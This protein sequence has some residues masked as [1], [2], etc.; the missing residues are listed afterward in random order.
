MIIANGRAQSDRG[1]IG[2]LG[3]RLWAAR[4]DVAAAHLWYTNKPR[5]S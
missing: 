2:E 4:G 1:V 3:D 5:I